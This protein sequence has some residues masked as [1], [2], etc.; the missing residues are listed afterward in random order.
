MAAI[1]LLIYT[2]TFSRNAWSWDR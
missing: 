2:I 1:K